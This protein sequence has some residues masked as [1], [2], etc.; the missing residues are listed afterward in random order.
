[1]T[2]V[3]L[4]TIF[5]FPFSRYASPYFFRSF[6][7]ISHSFFR[8]LRLLMIIG[9]PDG[10]VLTTCCRILSLLCH[11]IYPSTRRHLLTTYGFHHTHFLYLFKNFFKNF[12]GHFLGPQ[13]LLPS[14]FEFPFSRYVSPYFFR[15][16]DLFFY[17]LLHWIETTDDY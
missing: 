4:P 16:P 14:I 9:T 17:A 10:G 7:L 15:R 11:Q 5:E 12:L 3:L 6:E 13:G 1:V 2:Q 8:G